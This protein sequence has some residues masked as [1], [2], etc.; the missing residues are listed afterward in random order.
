MQPL[1]NNTPTPGGFFVRLA[2]YLIDLLLIGTILCLAVRLPFWFVQMQNPE[3]WFLRPVLFQ[4]SPYHIFL[5][6]AMS[7]YFIFMTYTNGA[8][9]GKRLMNL[10][11][12]STEGD[13]LTLFNVLYRETIGRYLSSLLFIG[14]LMIGGSDSKKALHDL[15]CN[16][17]VI[18]TCK[19]KPTFYGKA[20]ATYGYGSFQPVTQPS[21]PVSYRPYGQPGAEPA[22]E[23]GT[24]QQEA[25]P[26]AEPHSQENQ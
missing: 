19:C 1:E 9:V 22:G 12:I 25:Q 16:T 24:P 13:K 10:R 6:L 26:L 2:A 15:L 11:V 21:S 17:Q 4:F 23:L 7:A 3:N 18:Y 14:Y 8:T 20:P 5:Y